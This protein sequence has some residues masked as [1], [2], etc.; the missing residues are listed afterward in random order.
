MY[1]YACLAAY[2]WPE[3]LLYAAHIDLCAHL[4]IKD[5]HPPQYY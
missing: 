4:E 3:L 5:N 1:M 2:T